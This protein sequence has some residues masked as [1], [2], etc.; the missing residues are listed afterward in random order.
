MIGLMRRV[1]DGR[2]NVFPLQVGMVA[3]DLLKRSAGAA[4]IVTRSDRCEFMDFD[5]ILQ[6]H[7]IVVPE[8]SLD[9]HA[10]WGLRL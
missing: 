4:S 8:F 6:R 2:K 10:F 5:P 9:L 7:F 3:E 1:L